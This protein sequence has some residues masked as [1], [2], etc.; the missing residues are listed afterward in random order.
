M[1]REMNKFIN[2]QVVL[3]LRDRELTVSDIRLKQFQQ[4]KYEKYEMALKM[5]VES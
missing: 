4:E 1:T 3:S 5:L 2:H